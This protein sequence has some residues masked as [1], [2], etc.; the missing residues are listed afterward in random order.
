M[1]RVFESP[2]TQVMV[3]LA[4]VLFPGLALGQPMTIERALS[5]VDQ[6]GELQESNQALVQGLEA[7]A[8]AAARWPGP[9]ISAEWIAVPDRESELE[10]TVGQS[11]PVDSAPS[12]ASEAL[13]EEA[14][15]AGFSAEARIQE[16]KGEVAGVFYGAIFQ[17]ERLA[18][19]EER[20]AAVERTGGFL[21][22]RQAA[23][24]AS[25]F[26]VERVDREVRRL[27]LR[28]DREKASIQ[29][30]YDTLSALLQSEVDGVDGQ[31]G[32]ETC[33][34]KAAV[35]PR[36]AAQQAEVEAAMTRVRAAEKTW[37][38]EVGIEAGWILAFN[39][40]DESANGY[41]LGL[42]LGLPLWASSDLAVEAAE[43]EVVAGRADAAL[44]QRRIDRLARSSAELC[45][46]LQNNAQSIR[47]AIP[48][49]R[50][51]LERAESGYQAGELSLLELLDAQEA[52]LE[53]RLDLIETQFKARRAQIEWKST[54]GGW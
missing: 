2:M 44:I 21:Q 8:E 45:R 50:K 15:A 6:I 46:A 17:R 4:V 43:A 27:E 3:V 36:I 10:V 39:E 41:I 49:T 11:L 37:I 28:I 54:T 23:G 13:A 26:E 38:P 52:V 51:L 7:R 20:A 9:G 35:P 42:S 30:T 33:G 12:L 25:L 16:Y 48:K 1:T 24:D 47:E 5:Q 22:R 32:V 18:V 29:Q 14:R 34:G 19:L 53:D 31:L 40:L